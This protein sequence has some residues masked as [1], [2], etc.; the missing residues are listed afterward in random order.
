MSEENK[1]GF[2]KPYLRPGKVRGE[3]R[4]KKPDEEEEDS[5]DEEDDF[6]GGSDDEDV[7]KLCEGNSRYDH[8]TC[9]HIFF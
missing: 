4:K 9:M 6:E 8:V 2:C 7:R 5:D 3:Q 1:S